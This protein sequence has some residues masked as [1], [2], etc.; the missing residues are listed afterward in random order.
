MYRACEVSV[1]RACCERDTQPYSI[2]AGAR[3]YKQVTT[4]SPRIV[5][6]YLLTLSML[7]RMYVHDI[8]SR[9]RAG[10]IVSV[11]KLEYDMD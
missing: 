8:Y 3:G 4:R 9:F 6:E 1:H 5:T 2:G 10:A 7:I 11:R